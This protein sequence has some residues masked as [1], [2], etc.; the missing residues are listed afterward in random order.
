MRSIELKHQ[1]TVVSTNSRLSIPRI[2]N[3]HTQAKASLPGSEPE[4]GNYLSAANPYE[5]RYGE[6]WESEIKKVKSMTKYCDVHD[7]V[8]H[9]HDVTR[10]AFKGTRYK[11]TYLFYHDVL[12]ST[13]DKDC[14]DWI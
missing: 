8:S 4:P 9:I 6:N 5:A 2:K 1:L 14:L 10:D 12:I 7:L 13:T 3:L 11:E